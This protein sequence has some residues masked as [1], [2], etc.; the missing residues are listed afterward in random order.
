M[1]STC[2][3]AQ[4][5]GYTIRNQQDSGGD[6]L[7]SQMRNLVAKHLP[8]VAYTIIFIL[9]AIA[10]TFNFTLLG[11]TAE[12]RVSQDVDFGEGWV[13]PQGEKVAL[14][15][16][17]SLK[18][19]REHGATIVNRLPNS[20]ESG[21]ELNFL[22][23][24]CIFHVFYD[25]VEVYSYDP[26]TVRHGHAYGAHFN[27]APL[28]PSDAGKLVTIKIS[29][30]YPESASR[31][32]GMRLSGTAAY[33]QRFVRS[34]LP[35]TIVSLFIIF[36]GF[37]VLI[38]Y[39]ALSRFGQGDLDLLSLGTISALLGT[40]SLAETLVPQLITGLFSLIS[41]LDYLALLFVPYPMVRFA[42]SLIRPTYRKRYDTIAKIAAAISV[43]LTMVLS[44]I[45][46]LDMHQLLTISHAQLILLAI[47]IVC[48]V[49]ES[50]HEHGYSLTH[51]MKESNRPILISFLVC[52]GCA[53]ADFIIYNVTSSAP[54]DSAFFIRFG[55]FAFTITLAIEAFRTSMYYMRRANHADD[56]EAIAYVD[57]LTGIGNR[58]AFHVMCAEISE[59]LDDGTVDDAMVCQFDVNFLKQVNDTWGHAEGDE[60]LRRCA[61]TINRSFGTEGACYR[62]G[63][64]EFTALLV[65]INL[66]ERLELCQRLLEESI[67]EQNEAGEGKV[68]LSI[69]YGLACVS[70]TSKRNLDA[71][72]SLADRR[73]YANKH[74][75]KCERTD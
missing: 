2:H 37:A 32:Q 9:C 36:I 56:I 38:L 34:A 44:I 30:V 45:V 41:A 58:T 33:I 59:A 16:L 42:G 66:P 71:A 1:V 68:E 5:F 21:I 67:H 25:D 62:T 19:Y 10:L 18:N 48:E 8:T 73:M 17:E 50:F 60:H 35:A 29:P 39:T 51:G 43:G 20:I 4:P 55:L 12:T 69:A 31:I 57:A 75:M 26:D 54:I 3:H 6:F 14:G 63:G 11:G 53:F 47:L 27:F 72:M 70:E 40:W 64:D 24:N 52:I 61:D 22:S 7:A 65:G 49:L 28:N 15:A 13:T 23:K 74:A 46:R